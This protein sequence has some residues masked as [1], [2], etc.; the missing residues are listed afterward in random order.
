MLQMLH[1]MLSWLLLLMLSAWKVIS[2]I[3]PG[4]T[5]DLARWEPFNV[6]RFAFQPYVR[7]SWLT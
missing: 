7:N 2:Q 3:I 5:L 6:I 1:L 4:R